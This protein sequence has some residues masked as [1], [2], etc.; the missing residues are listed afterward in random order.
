MKV[1]V[2]VLYI[3][4]GEVSWLPKNDLAAC[5]ESLHTEC[6][7]DPAAPLLGIYPKKSL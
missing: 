5:S 7:L 6:V 2:N 3:I 4:S 1:Q